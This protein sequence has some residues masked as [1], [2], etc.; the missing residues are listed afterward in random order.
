MVSRKRIVGVTAASL[1]VVGILGVGRAYADDPKRT[2]L[3]TFNK[4]IRLPGVTL[5]AGTYLFNHP[6]PM[7]D[8]PVV[9]V[10]SEDSTQVYGTFLTIPD[11]RITVSE[12]TIVTFHETPVGS[13]DTVR[14]WF[15]PGE[16]IGDEF[17]YSKKEAT[18]IARRTHEA[19][20]SMPAPERIKDDGEPKPAAK[21]AAR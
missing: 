13:V 18:E 3:I 6:T 1:L 12:E 16:T 20:L 5:P 2:T 15:F 10:F 11:N 17:L 8:Y 7:N 14:A 9:Q 19:V 21:P 4:P